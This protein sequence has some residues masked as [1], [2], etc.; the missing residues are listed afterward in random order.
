[1]FRPFTY[2]MC[3]KFTTNFSWHH[4]IYHTCKLIF[5]PV[6]QP[7]IPARCLSTLYQYHYE[8]CNFRILHM[9]YRPKRIIYFFNSIM[10]TNCYNGSTSCTLKYRKFIWPNWQFYQSFLFLHVFK[11]FFFLVDVFSN[12]SQPKRWYIVV[13]WYN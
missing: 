10:Y 6:C 4:P 9:I 13:W 3:D 2:L 1:M 12:K 7:P 11:E 8:I 5:L